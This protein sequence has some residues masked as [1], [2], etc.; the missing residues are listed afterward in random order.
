M[1]V[2]SFNRFTTRSDFHFEQYG[3]DFSHFFLYYFTSF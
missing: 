1:Q 3:I 2:E